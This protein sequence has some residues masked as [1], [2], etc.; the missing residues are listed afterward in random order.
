MISQRSHSCLCSEE[1][2]SLIQ[3]CAKFASLKDGAK[4]LRLPRVVSFFFFSFL[5]VRSRY[6]NDK[7]E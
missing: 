7:V 4:Y 5:F 2:S 3:S 6:Y 1:R